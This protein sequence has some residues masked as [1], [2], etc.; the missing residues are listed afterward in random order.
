[1]QIA[2][3]SI[4]P[5][6]LSETLE[7]VS[8]YMPF[9]DEIIV[10]VPERLHSKFSVLAH[11]TRIIT[12]EE[13]MGA[14]FERY[15]KYDHQYKNYFLRT[16]MA[17]HPSIN[18]EFIMSDDDARPLKA[19]S[20]NQ[21]KD[22]GAYHSY[23]FYDLSL[24]RYGSGDFDVGQQSTYQALRYFDLPY[25]SFASHMPQI[26]NQKIFLEAAEYFELIARKYPLCEWSTYF[27]YATRRY[28]KLFH[29]PRPFQTLCWPDC[30][31][32]WP[33]FVRPGGYAFENFAAQLYRDGHPFQGIGTEFQPQLAGEVTLDKIMRWYQFELKSQSPE[34]VEKIREF[35]VGIWRRVLMAI[36]GPT[37]KLYRLVSW[38]EHARMVEL[39]GRLNSL[40]RTLKRNDKNFP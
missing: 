3:I 8:A 28:P 15:S 33:H 5:D 20:I 17:A 19:I 4:R 1:M 27:N 12:D 16:Q 25:L 34:L 18:S 22:G 32:C 9:V 31:T 7:Y 38:E 11:H 26:I 24:W 36:L 14:A 13:I 40:E 23:Y 35:P 21:Y 29:D 2:Y 30:P 37:R 39:T 6:V 10:V